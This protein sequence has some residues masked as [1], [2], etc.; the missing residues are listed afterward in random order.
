MGV[1][2]RIG[3][4]LICLLLMRFLDGKNYYNLF[5]MILIMV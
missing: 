4:I 1:L 2:K 3:Y 5:I